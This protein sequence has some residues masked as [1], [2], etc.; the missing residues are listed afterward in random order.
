[1]A[2]WTLRHPLERAIS[3]ASATLSKGK[4]AEMYLET[5]RLPSSRSFMASGNGPHREPTMFN[6]WTTKAD[7]SIVACEAHVDFKTI[8][9]MAIVRVAAIL[10]PSTVPVASTTT[11]KAPRSSSGSAEASRGDSWNTTASPRSAAS[12]WVDRWARSAGRQ[13]FT[14]P[15]GFARSRGF[16]D[17]RPSACPCVGPSV[18]L[19]RMSTEQGHL[20][21][22]ALPGQDLCD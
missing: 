12:Q 15:F 20:R 22:Q 1:M 7:V 3:N 2:S 21:G 4:T 11:S 10:R 19:G 8:V 5:S 17:F 9:P 18:S 13:L 6:S 16:L 14:R